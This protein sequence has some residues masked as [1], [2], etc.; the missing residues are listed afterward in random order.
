V[1]F[2]VVARPDQERV[3]PVRTIGQVEARLVL[4]LI[5][6]QLVQVKVEESRFTVKPAPVAPPV[7]VPTE[8]I[9]VWA[10]FTSKAPALKVRPVPAV[11]VAVQV[12]TPFKRARMLPAVPAVV[13]ARALEPFPYGIVPD[14]M[15]AQPVPPFPTP[16]MPV[17]SEVKSMRAVATAPAVAL[18]KPETLEKVKLFEATRLDDEAVPETARLDEVALVVVELPVTRRSESMV[19]VPVE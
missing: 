8:V 6:R 14:W 19:V 11:V 12:G 3:S 5:S 15:A 1:G 2:E 16:S 13:V 9:W 7:R 18:R 10:A 4:S 17:I